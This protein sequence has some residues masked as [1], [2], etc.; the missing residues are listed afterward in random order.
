MDQQ[1]FLN[2]N[3]RQAIANWLYEGIAIHYK[4]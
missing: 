3:N 2:P 4:K 1:R